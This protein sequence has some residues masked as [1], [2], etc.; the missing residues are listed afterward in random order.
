MKPSFLTESSKD[1]KETETIMSFGA[2]ASKNT[3]DSIFDDVHERMMGEQ[4]DVK[5]DINMLIK[6]PALMESYKENLLGALGLSIT[7]ESTDMDDV[8]DI[9]AQRHLNLCEAVSTLWDNCANDLYTESTK[10]GQ[11]LPYQAVDFPILVKQ[12][13]KVCAKDIIQTEVTK[14]PLIKKQIERTYI[15]DPKANGGKGKRYEYPQCFFN[16]EFKE[17]W[18][19]G[20]GF[21]IKN[22]WVDI[23]NGLF[24]Y[25]IIENLTDG[26]PVRDK[27][28]LD[29]RIT[30]V[31]DTDGNEYPVNIRVNLNDKKFLNGDINVKNPSN[32]EV[33]DQLNGSVDYLTSTCNLSACNGK[34]AAV[35]FSGYVS[36]ELN[37]R[38]VTM[39]YAREELEWKIEDGFRMNVP[40]SLE[41]LTDAKALLDIDLYKKTYDN[42]TDIQVQ[43]EDANILEYLDKKFDEY[44]GIEV[45]PLDFTPFVRSK[46]FDCEVPSSIVMLQ[47]EYIEKHLK[48]V[49]DRLISLISDDA[50]LEDMTFVIYGNPIYVSLLGNAVNWV[51]SFGDM[52]GGVKSNYSYGIMNTGHVKIQVVATSKVNRK[53][54]KGLRLIPFPLNKEQFTFKHYKY[55]QHILTERNSAYRDPTLP[56]GS[57]TNLMA[58]N[59]CKTVCVQGIQGSID[60]VNDDLIV[61]MT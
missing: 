4:V 12:H 47:E 60:F 20:K 40:Y 24:D 13:L 54:H 2:N 58:T 7:Q 30:R 48:Y 5:N 29:L 44:K 45:N 49:I 34:I 28:S 10:V 25:N 22:D 46:E 31:K 32:N 55:T 21:P 61:S 37:E 14:S 17:I 19:A 26:D 1:F 41:E 16:D 39:D 38:H 9:K 27:L 6:N 35:Q 18:A 51:T 57:M 52:V 33:K 42:L 8:N 53:T 59:R 43:M 36:N 23:S 50:K 11:L 15:V 56:G 3:F